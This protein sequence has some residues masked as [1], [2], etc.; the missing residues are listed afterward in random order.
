MEF[1]DHLR[2]LFW[3]YLDYTPLRPK[4]RPLDAKD[5][6]KLIF[7]MVL[8]SIAGRVTV[9]DKFQRSTSILTTSRWYTRD[10]RSDGFVS[11]R[12]LRIGST[13][14]YFCSSRRCTM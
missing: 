8:E 3:N 12:S 9:R 7:A 6:W 10:S 5:L 4:L 11:L 1:V 2:R 14:S 13:S